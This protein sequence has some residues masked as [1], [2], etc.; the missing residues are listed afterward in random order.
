[1]RKP[2]EVIS[3]VGRVATLSRF[4][5]RTTNRYVPFFNALRESKTFESIEKSKT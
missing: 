3:L 2:N 1:M 4:M 5:L